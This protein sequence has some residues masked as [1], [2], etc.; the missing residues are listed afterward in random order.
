MISL[1]CRSLCRIVLAASFSFSVLLTALLF[2]FPAVAADRVG[3]PVTFQGELKYQS[4]VEDNMDL[5]DDGLEHTPSLEGKLKIKAFL[6]QDISVFWEGR[7]VKTRRGGTVED[8]DGVQTAGN[9]DAFA[10][11]R[12][13]WL[14][15]DEA[16]GV[17]PLSFQIGRQ[18]LSEPRALWWNKNFDAARVIY[19]TTLFSG[20]FG[21]GEDLFS[22]KTSQDDFMESDE[23]RL[24]AFAEGSWLYRPDHH[25]D[26]RVLYEDDHSGLEPV[27]SLISSNDRDNTDANLLWVG[28]RLWGDHK[29]NS[30]FV[31][32]LEY[33]VDLMGV[34]GTE[35]TLAST[36]SGDP[37]FRTVTGDSDRDILGWGLDAAVDMSLNAPWRPTLTLGYAF[38]SGDDDTSDGT[39]NA[40]RQTGLH[41]NATRI[42]VSGSGIR[43]YG[44]ALRPELSN[45][46]ILTAG[47]GFPVLMASDVTFLY[48]A[49]FLDEKDAPLGSTA[50]TGTLNGL[51]SSVGQGLDAVANFDLTKELNLNMLMVEKTNLRMAVGA[52]R[53]GEAYTPEDGDTAVRGVMEVRF[54]F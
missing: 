39:D 16:F 36:A 9:V 40:F 1:L 10:E 23:Q 21:V 17:I 19:D 3:P 35:D 28:G 37:A 46:H 43:N 51:D 48:H 14:R 12:Q 30:R 50:V 18:R 2:A 42:G 41:G 45:L 29:V 47:V 24:R 26:L 49:Y 32:G 15:F 52:F 27:G 5:V 20:M 22:Y 8:D 54:Q 11:W 31:G 6:P 4:L 33:A 34:R 38:G 13:S 25:A 44:E 53:A 7:A